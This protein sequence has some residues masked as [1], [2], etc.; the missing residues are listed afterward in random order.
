[1]WQN[2]LIALEQVR[3]WFVALWVE[4]IR[5]YPAASLDVQRKLLDLSHPIL[6]NAPSLESRILDTS[7]FVRLITVN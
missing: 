4:L 3:G 6:L 1:L 5:G 2:G 7:I